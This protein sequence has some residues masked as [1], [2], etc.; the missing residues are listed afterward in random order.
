MKLD[1]VY[2]NLTIKTGAKLALIVLDGLGDLATGASNY[3]TP[4]GFRL[5]HGGLDNFEEVHPK[6]RPL[7][8]RHSH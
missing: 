4:F 8:E 7:I 1:S 3:L 6:L 5:G 2:S